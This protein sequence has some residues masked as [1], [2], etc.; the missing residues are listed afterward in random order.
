MAASTSNPKVWR[1]WVCEEID[2]ENAVNLDDIE[3]VASVQAVVDKFQRDFD[4]PVAATNKLNIALS[5]GGK[6][7]N[8][9]LE[10]HRRTSA[11]RLHI[12]SNQ[13]LNS[14]AEC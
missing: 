2:S 13:K 9:C 3:N 10:D 1:A 5:N 11:L 14:Q 12:P 8:A 4:E 6:D 7:I